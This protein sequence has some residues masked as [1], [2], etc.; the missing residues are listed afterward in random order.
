M[1]SFA[2]FKWSVVTSFLLNR[3]ASQ[4]R[5][6]R[7]VNR[8]VLFAEEQWR[9]EDEQRR[10]ERRRRLQRERLNGEQLLIDAEDAN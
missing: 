8:P 3:M 5:S 1:L 7:N 10:K 6:G 4:T 9:P 2:L